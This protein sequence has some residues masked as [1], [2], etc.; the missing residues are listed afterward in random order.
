MTD[1]QAA[2]AATDL[3]A[4][5]RDAAFAGMY[6]FRVVDAGV[7]SCTLEVPFRESF[8]RPGGVVSGPVY[9]AAADAAMWLAILT[10]T[11]IGDGHWVTIGMTSSFL[12]GAR[13]SDLRCTATVLRL[14]TR[15]AHGLAEIVDRDDRLLAHHTLTY[16]LAQAR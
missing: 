1:I 3:E 5:L 13:R 12:R 16:T 11:G 15:I 8:E 7:G 2:M 6:G 10:R 14:G 9:M 4:V